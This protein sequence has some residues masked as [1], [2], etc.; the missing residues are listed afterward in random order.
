MIK[1]QPQTARAVLASLKN[2]EA[3]AL[4]TEKERRRVKNQILRVAEAIET[5]ERQRKAASLRRLNEFKYG[6]DYDQ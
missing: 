4:I 2:I 3:S 5:F 6:R 1:L